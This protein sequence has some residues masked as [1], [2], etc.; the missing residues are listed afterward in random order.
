MKKFLTTILVITIGFWEHAG[1]GKITG[2]IQNGTAGY[3][4]PESLTVHLNRYRGGKQDDSFQQI[5]NLKPGGRFF[6]LDLPEGEE[7]IYEPMVYYEGI[8]YYGTAIT[9]SPTS[10]TGKSEIR[11]YET[12]NDDSAISAV[13]HHLILESGVGLVQVRE[14]IVLQNKSDRTY[15]GK[16]HHEQ[17]FHTIDYKLP[18]NAVN[19]RLGQGL[20]SC[21]IQSLAD[22]FFDTMELLPGRK[23]VDFSYQI[24]S[25]GSELQFIKPITVQTL[26]F[27]ILVLDTT[28]Q[29]SGA[30][31]V[32]MPVKNGNYK[33]YVAAH[34]QP[35]EKMDL[36]LAGLTTPPKDFS[37]LMMILFVAFLLVVL[38]I[39]SKKFKNHGSGSSIP[40][41]P[42]NPLEEENAFPPE[43]DLA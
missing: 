42:E 3:T 17:Q 6:F 38:F 29:V 5:T 28:L 24:Q 43:E 33:R 23:E 19:I 41:S 36:H 13:I 7:Y 14:V 11:I 22:G 27:D 10:P 16:D 15:V 18:P 34:F 32:E 35:G 31:I 12:T 39:A 40:A 21:C 37:T 2:V 4:I 30:R 1:A 8:K 25:S 26:A 20:M 9:I